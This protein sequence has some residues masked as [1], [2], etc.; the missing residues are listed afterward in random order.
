MQEVCLFVVVYWMKKIFAILFLP[1]M[2]ASGIQVSIDHHYCG[3]KLAAT[4]ISLSGKL[5]SCGME[6]Q[7]HTCSNQPSVDKNCC[8]DQLTYYGINT[9][10]VPEYFK[11]SSP[12]LVKDIPDFS[13]YNF[14]LNHSDENTFTSWV[15]PPGDKIKSG[16]SLS[17][18]CVFRI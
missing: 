6:E 5:A 3:G 7:E 2:L 14:S 18:I 17:E 11:L 15:F 16:R 4:K 10:Y 9:S 12:S 8:E 13:V 1:V